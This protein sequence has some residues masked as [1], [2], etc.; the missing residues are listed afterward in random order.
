M[1]ASQLIGSYFSFSIPYIHVGLRMASYYILS[2][3]IDIIFDLNNLSFSNKAVS[4]NYV[5]LLYNDS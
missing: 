1:I 3:N 5:K 4:V 2:P